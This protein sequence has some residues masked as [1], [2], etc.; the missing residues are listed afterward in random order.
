MAAD[1]DSH[2][3]IKTLETMLAEAKAALA[4][5]DYDDVGY[6]A[7]RL[8]REAGELLQL[9]QDR[10]YAFPQLSLARFLPVA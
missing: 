7:S 8:C 3:C 10:A 2:A 1:K 4:D 9:A 6:Y 5:G